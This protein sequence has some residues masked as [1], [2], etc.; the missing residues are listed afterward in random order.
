MD[1]WLDETGDAVAQARAPE[2]LAVCATKTTQPNASSDTGSNPCAWRFGPRTH[3]PGFPVQDSAIHRYH[4]ADVDFPVQ[5]GTR[6]PSTIEFYDP[7]AQVVQIDPVFQGYKIVVLD[8]VILVV[9][10]ATREIVDVI[11]T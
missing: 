9:D 3:S 4:R 2:S 10:P 7:P 6:I 8:D 11:R 1:G 5:V